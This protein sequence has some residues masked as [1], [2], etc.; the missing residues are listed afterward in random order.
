VG[1]HSQSTTNRKHLNK[2]FPK[3]QLS[4]QLLGSKS[5]TPKEKFTIATFHT[6]TH[7]S[8]QSFSAFYDLFMQPCWLHF[9]FHRRI[10]NKVIRIEVGWANGAGKSHKIADNNNRLIYI[11]YM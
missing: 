7:F 10:W 6:L 9:H 8:R 2:T 3:L 11:I 4:L 5:A 1:K